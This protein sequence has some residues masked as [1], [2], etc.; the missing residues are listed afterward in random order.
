MLISDLRVESSQTCIAGFLLLDLPVQISDTSD[1][2]CNIELLPLHVAQR[3]NLRRELPGARVVIDNS[4]TASMTAATE[5]P[6]V[7]SQPT[8]SKIEAKLCLELAVQ[9]GFRICAGN[10]A[11][12][13]G[14]DIGDEVPD[15]GVGFRM[16]QYICCI[17]SELQALALR[18]LDGL[19]DIRVKPPPAWSF[20]GPQADV[21]SPA[22]K[23]ILKQDLT[24]LRI[25]NGINGAQVLKVLRRRNAP[26][27]RIFDLRYRA[28][29]KVGSTAGAVLPLNFR[30]VAIKGSHD[31]GSA[32]GVKHVLSAHAQWLS[33]VQVHDPPHLPILDDPRQR[34]RAIAEEHLGRTDRQHERSIRAKIVFTAVG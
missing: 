6:S 28:P 30:S 13:R 12:V 31:L 22:G 7:R 1:E 21:A 17:Q 2:R 23:W 20:Q 4:F 24:S 3:P 25:S 27:L 15:R 33:A 26:A 19:A 5:E 32:V 34:P 9:S 18:D 11:E 14:V 8:S 10:Q 29:H 16:V